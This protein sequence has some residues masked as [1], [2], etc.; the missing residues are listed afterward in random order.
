MALD[1]HLPSLWFSLLSSKIW[2]VIC[3]EYWLPADGDL[4]KVPDAWTEARWKDARALVNIESSFYKLVG[5]RKLGVLDPAFLRL[6]AHIVIGENPIQ[7]TSLLSLINL[8]KLS[9]HLHSGPSCLAPSRMLDS[10][11]SENMAGLLWP[12]VSSSSN[13]L[14]SRVLALQYGKPAFY[15]IAEGCLTFI[16]NATKRTC[17]GD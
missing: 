12:Y 5:G 11:I 17:P 8:V 3:S 14:T 1:S 7:L 16:I 10:S 13:W 4:K 15:H 9:C 2:Q 6:V